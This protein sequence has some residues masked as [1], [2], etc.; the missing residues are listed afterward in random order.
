MNV[1]LLLREDTMTLLLTDNVNRRDSQPGLC[2]PRMH[3][4]SLCLVL[5]AVRVAD[6]LVQR[7][8]LHLLVV[9]AGVRGHPVR[10]QLIT[11]AVSLLLLLRPGRVHQVSF[12]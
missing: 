11:L 4:I 9:L 1:T 3:C 6:Q 12:M 5:V 2:F 10:V 8:D 7:E